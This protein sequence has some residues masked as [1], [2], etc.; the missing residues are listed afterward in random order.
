M[1]GPIEGPKKVGNPPPIFGKPQ[2]KFG[3]E[4]PLGVDQEGPFSLILCVNFVDI[5]VVLWF[6]LLLRAEPTSQVL[7]GVC[8]VLGSRINFSSHG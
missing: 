6:I 2:E 1:E 5:F 7:F 3:I 8:G 4:G